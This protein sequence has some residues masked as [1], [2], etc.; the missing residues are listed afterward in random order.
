M[1]GIADRMGVETEADADVAEITQDIA[2]E[3][4]LDELEAAEP[5]PS[6]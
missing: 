3:A 2:P 6:R 4:V 1:S 5:A